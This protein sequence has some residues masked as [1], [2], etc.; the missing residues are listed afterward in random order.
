ML[1]PERYFFPGLSRFKRLVG[2]CRPGGGGRAAPLRK[3]TF[4]LLVWV[5]IMPERKKERSKKKTRG[6]ERKKSREKDMKKP[7]YKQK[8]K[9]KQKHKQKQTT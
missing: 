4:K 6:E 2:G 1:L 9:H 3:K 7:K 5:L 8:Q